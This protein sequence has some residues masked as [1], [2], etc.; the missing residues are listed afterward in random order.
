MLDVRDLKVDTMTHSKF[1]W[2]WNWWNFLVT[3]QDCHHL[4]PTL[5]SCVSLLSL[6]DGRRWCGQ[7][8]EVG[9]AKEGQACLAEQGLQHHLKISVKANHGHNHNANFLDY[10]HL[11]NH[12]KWLQ[13]WLE[14][15]QK[16]QNQNQFCSVSSR[17]GQARVRD[18]DVS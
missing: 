5:L 11:L 3:V 8:G 6:A 18:L 9:H 4:T 15:L 17:V 2:L 16:I 14:L 1:L 13:E 12:N 7:D 10:Q